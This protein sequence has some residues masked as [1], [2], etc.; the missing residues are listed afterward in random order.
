[1]RRNDTARHFQNYLVV[2]LRNL[3]ETEIIKALWQINLFSRLH[4]VRKNLK[5]S[6]LNKGRRE[7][8]EGPKIHKGSTK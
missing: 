6:V 4:L 8:N 3:S 5:V 2:L 7:V 1:M